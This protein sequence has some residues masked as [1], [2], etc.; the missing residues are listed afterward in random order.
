M[1][2]IALILLMVSLIVIA[3]KNDELA[4]NNDFYH[5]KCTQQLDEI[6]ELISENMQLKNYLNKK[7]KFKIVTSRDHFEIHS[8]NNT[9]VAVSRIYT[10]KSHV[11]K[12][13]RSI[14]ESSGWRISKR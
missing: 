5:N 8:I 9:C 12:L 10:Y 7:R 11:L 2:T 14:S 6:Q 13:A 3:V 4:A 1:T